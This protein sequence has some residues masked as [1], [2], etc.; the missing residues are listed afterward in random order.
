MLQAIMDG[1]RI[2]N[3]SKTVMKT[4]NV[5]IVVQGGVSATTVDVL[6]GLRK[7][8][9]KAEIILSTWENSDLRGLDYDKVLLSPDPGAQM[10]DEAAGVYNNV[11]RQIVSTQ[12]GLRAATRP[13]I[14]KTRTDILFK[15]AKFLSYFGLFDTEPPLYFKNRL[16]ICNYYTRNPRV[17]PVCFHPSDWLLFGLAEDMRKY[18]ENIPLMAREEGEWFLTHRKTSS[19]FKNVLFR[20]APE[21]HIFLNFLR[22]YENVSCNQYYD[23]SP[24]S[25]EQTERVF[26]RCFVVLDYQKQL[27]IEF[28]KYAPNRYW[29]GFTLISH[30]R[31]KAL[32]RRYCEKGYRPW[33]FEY[34]V[35]NLFL[36]F[37]SRGRIWCIRILNFLGVKERVKRCLNVL[38]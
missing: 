23:A 17:W 5:S 21:Q 32:Y 9:P 19:L 28:T 38:L 10:A 18:Y 36:Q 33:Q 27:N 15:D 31:W 8:F 26:A 16:L 14:L 29:E 7:I 25:I 4:N 2:K 24:A 34:W 3:K 11:N 1:L 37:L 20:F 12:A 30:R 6:H 35:G 22:Q 13:Y